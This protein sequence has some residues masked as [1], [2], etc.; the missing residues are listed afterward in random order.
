MAELPL[1]AYLRLYVN[2]DCPYD[3]FEATL[4]PEAPWSLEQLSNTDKE[5]LKL[6]IKENA[7]QEFLEESKEHMS[8]M[9]GLIDTFQSLYLW[10]S[11]KT[12]N[13]EEPLPRA[14]RYS[15]DPQEVRVPPVY[16]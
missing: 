12:V 4:V 15:L 14:P 13:Y 9:S 10:E 8:S 2:Y 11:F 1:P 5:E 16:V 3:G 7:S 6:F